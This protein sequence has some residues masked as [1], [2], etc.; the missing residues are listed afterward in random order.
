MAQIR[1]I[2][3]HH[4]GLARP[5]RRGLGGFPVRFDDLCSSSPTSAKFNLLLRHFRSGMLTRFAE[6]E[7]W[8][9]DA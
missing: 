7:I 9:G 6:I 3:F 5:G 8:T 1:T 2:A 4:D